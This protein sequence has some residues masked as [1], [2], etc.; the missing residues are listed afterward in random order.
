YNFN[1]EVT[2]VSYTRFRILRCALDGTGCESV[3]LS[4]ATGSGGSLSAPQRIIVDATSSKVLVLGPGQ[5]GVGIGLSRCNSDL[6]GCVHA[7]ISPPKEQNASA[8]LASAVLDATAARLVM[9]GT[10]QFSRLG[11]L[12][13]DL[14]GTNCQYNGLSDRGPEFAPSMAID[15]ARGK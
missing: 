7:D 1:D 3:D 2:S 13:C 5:S 12:R 6:T 4:D 14:D 11:M 9:V 10:S 15:T 8:L